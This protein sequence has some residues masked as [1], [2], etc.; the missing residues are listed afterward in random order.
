MYAKKGDSDKPNTIVKLQTK[1]GVQNIYFSK[2]I[3]RDLKLNQFV[4]IICRG[5]ATANASRTWI[6]GM[7]CFS[8]GHFGHD[9]NNFILGKALTVTHTKSAVIVCTKIKLRGTNETQAPVWVRIV[10]SGKL[11]E[12]ARARIQKGSDLLLWTSKITKSGS[13]ENPTYSCFCNK[14]VSG[15]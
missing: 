2:I 1:G 12:H 14:F 3:R 5:S 4:A 8:I 10:F 13:Y 6:T 7:E 9:T 11:L 15:S